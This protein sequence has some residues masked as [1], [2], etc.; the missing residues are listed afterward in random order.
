[1]VRSN[2]LFATNASTARKTTAERDAK[3]VGEMPTASS[4]ANRLT[5][6]AASAEPHCPDSTNDATKPESIVSEAKITIGPQSSP[7]K[8]VVR[9]SDSRPGRAG[10]TPSRHT[11]GAFTGSFAR[12]IKQNKT[13]LARPTPV[14]STSCATSGNMDSPKEISAL[15]SMLAISV[16]RH[17]RGP[18]P[19][20]GTSHAA[21]VTFEVKPQIDASAIIPASLSRPSKMP[22]PERTFM[23]RSAAA[24]TTPA[25]CRREFGFMQLHA[26]K[27]AE[28]SRI[29]NED[30]NENS[31]LTAFT[32]VM[33]R[34]VD[35]ADEYVAF[36]NT[37]KKP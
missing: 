26:T 18:M 14:R 36:S 34:T 16:V 33:S 9:F 12:H 23:M 35:M 6:L 4:V 30:A 20:N 27:A 29:E 15:T 7:S 22:M 10:S 17:R 5:P 19:T 8:S 25:T 13:M 1:M 32:L 37:R 21:L 3:L 11:I 24:E 31:K 2:V 28:V